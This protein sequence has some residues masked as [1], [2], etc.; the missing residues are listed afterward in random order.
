MAKEIERKFLMDLAH[1]P[2]EAKGVHFEQG[3]IAITDSGIVRVRIIRDEV[4]TLTV[5][6]S[7][8]GLSR[9]EFQYEIPIDEAKAL[10]KL[11][12]ND[13][14]EKTR[15]HIIVEEKQWDVDQFH[16][17]NAGLWVAEVEL[18]SEDEQVTLP[19]WVTNEVTGDEHY[20]NAFISKHP[21]NTW[22]K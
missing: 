6:S 19:K 21:Y 16:G 18:I 11:C 3:Y 5:K 4:S 1:W 8:T 20:Y 13:I 12:Q 9:D 7:G 17:N 15:Y 22:E 2:N 10:L 14:I